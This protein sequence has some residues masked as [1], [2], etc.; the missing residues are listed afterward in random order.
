MGLAKGAPD[1]LSRKSSSPCAE[2]FGTNTR[3]NTMRF[4]PQREGHMSAN[5]IDQ[6][7]AFMI[8]QVMEIVAQASALTTI[9]G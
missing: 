9:I 7:R 1:A 2:L 3:S 8:S 6:L 4:Y 5:V